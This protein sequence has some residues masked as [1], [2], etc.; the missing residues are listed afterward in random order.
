MWSIERESLKE[1]SRLNGINSLNGFVD[2]RSD[3][4]HRFDTFQETNLFLKTFYSAYIFNG[5]RIFFIKNK[6]I[7]GA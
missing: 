5:C 1:R 2:L 6:I 7:C 4:K 3:W